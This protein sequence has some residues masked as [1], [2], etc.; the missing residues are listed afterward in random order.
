MCLLYD[1]MDNASTGRIHNQI[2]GNAMFTIL[3][4]PRDSSEKVELD[5]VAFWEIRDAI[6]LWSRRGWICQIAA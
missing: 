2:K 1:T 6:R 5:V 3:G 4:H